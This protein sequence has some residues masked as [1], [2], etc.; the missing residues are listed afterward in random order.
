MKSRKT[1]IS[2]LITLALLISAVGALPISVFAIAGGGSP[3]YPDSIFVGGVEMAKDTYLASGASSTTN[4]APAEGGYA[5]Y[6]DDGVLTLNNYVYSGDGTIFSISYKSVIY[7]EDSG[8]IKINLIGENTLTNTDDGS[9]YDPY[10]IYIEDGALD[11]SGDGAL[12]INAITGITVPGGYV[13]IGSGFLLI[14]A[15]WGITESGGFAMTGGTVKIIS[16]QAAISV[17]AA[18]SVSIS[19]GNLT[20]SNTSNQYSVINKAPYLEYYESDYTAVAGT[21]ADGSDAT[22]Y[23]AEAYAESPKSYKYFKIEGNENAISKFSVKGIDIPTVGETPA[24]LVHAPICGENYQMA[25]NWQI[26]YNDGSGWKYLNSD[27]TTP[28]AAGQEYVIK[29]YL[30]LDE[31]YTV[32]DGDNE[33][34]VNG[35]P[36]VLVDI[37][38]SD[39]LVQLEIEYTFTPELPVFEEYNIII[40]D[41][42]KTDPNDPG[43]RITGANCTDVFGDGTVSYDPETKTL[44]LDNYEYDGLGALNLSYVGI[45]F[46]DDTSYTIELKGRNS[47]KV[48]GEMSAGIISMSIYDL[49]FTGEGSLYVEASV[50]GI[51][52]ADDDKG[53]I[54]V[55]GGNITVATTEIP[56]MALFAGA[57][58]GI[59]GGSVKLES[60]MFGIMINSDDPYIYLA[61]GS[62]EVAV[63]TA[64]RAIMHSVDGGIDRAVPFAPE[65]RPDAYISTASVKSNGSEAVAYN[66]DDLATYKYV[67]LEV[68]PSYVEYDILISEPGNDDLWPQGV[69]ITSKNYTDVL[70]NGTVSYDPETKTLTLNNYVYEGNGLSYNTGGIV[71]YGEDANDYTILL[72][73]NNSIKLNNTDH[74]RGI[75]YEGLREDVALTITGDGSLTIQTS[76]IGIGGASTLEIKSGNVSVKSACGFWV[77]DKFVMNGG[78]LKIDAWSAVYVDKGVAKITGG[79]LEISITEAGCLFGYYD[80]EEDEELALAPDLSQYRGI[81]AVTASV[82]RNGSGAVTYN[83]ADIAS[84]KYLK[85]VHTHEF[86]TTWKTDANNHWKECECGEKSEMAAHVDDNEDNKCDV[87][88]YAMSAPEPETTEPIDTPEET[89]PIDTPEETEEPIDTPE[90]TE[91][92][93]TPE[94]TDQPDAPTG[95]ETTLPADTSPADDDGGLG[96]GAIIGI[97]IGS[98][99]VVGIG[100]FALFWFVIKKKSFADLIAVFKK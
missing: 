78:S 97:V 38:D 79:E 82:N 40:A 48:N 33:V 72:K 71:F 74:G 4:T 22:A 95:S 46:E 42:R 52:A 14:D 32:A 64:G 63:T 89:E 26:M 99:A 87:C 18:G 62:L 23:D 85:I 66:P 57:G 10:G 6:S 45:I 30:I 69:L 8:S 19:G 2:I 31:G 68:D 44:T 25:D 60:A 27:S 41:P 7:V 15:R 3:T 59:R 17:R 39:E 54:W 93:D 75:S 37:D 53:A 96:T 80:E 77:D 61:G 11:I 21:K 12:A 98:V 55:E 1:L 70:G 50:Y 67:K 35:N 90:E 76:A 81:Y 34:T 28:I 92:I 43:V 94:E 91:P 56:S 88:A 100:G 51:G 49:T 5:H 73:G 84:Y 36:A 13:N 20:A 16:E 9:A 29:L 65:F 83:P 86:G 47:I 24:D 58:V